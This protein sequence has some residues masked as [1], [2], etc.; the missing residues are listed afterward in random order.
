MTASQAALLA[1]EG[2][3]LAIVADETRRLGDHVI[4]AVEKAMIDGEEIN[5]DAIM[6]LAFQLNLLALNNAIESSRII[7]FAGKQAAVY[8]ES[9]RILAHE[10]VCLFGEETAAEAKQNPSPWAAEPSSVAENGE[11]LLLN[12]GGINFVE[13]LK[14]VKEI[15]VT[16]ERG[17][18]KVTIR[19]MELPLVD[20]YKMLGKEQETP[21]PALAII[22]TPWAAQNKTFAVTGYISGLFFSPVGKPMEPPSDMPLAK[23][24]RECWENE[25]GEP[26]YFMNWTKMA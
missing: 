8:A 22:W 26:F 2:K 15:H 18:G 12:A 25:N 6:P 4:N 14:N 5:K 24:V 11:F 19:N 7:G 16:P 17:E 3:G 1:N 10:I 20:I 13:S 23:Y 9:I 21:A